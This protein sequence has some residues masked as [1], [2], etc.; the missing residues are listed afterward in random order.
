ML[1]RTDGGGWEGTWVSSGLGAL[2][3]PTLLPVSLEGQGLTDG[4]FQGKSVLRV[5][6]FCPLSVPTAD[7]RA[8]PECGGG[9]GA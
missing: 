1:P 7:G 3:S 9:G 8:R 4:I 6:G 5:R 2:P